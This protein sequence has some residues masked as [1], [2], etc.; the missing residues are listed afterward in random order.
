MQNFRNTTIIFCAL[1]M[2]V[3]SAAEP[4]QARQEK[5]R[6]WVDTDAACV[7]RFATDVDDCWAL[8]LLLNSPNIQIVGIS[9][10]FGN[11]ERA[12]SVGEMRALLSAVSQV[13][14]NGRVFPVVEGAHEPSGDGPRSSNAAVEAL[15]AELEKAP[16]TVLALG[17]LTNIASATKRRPDLWHQIEQIVAVAGQ[18]PGERFYPGTSRLLHVHDMNFQKDVDAFETVL[19]LPTEITLIPYAA[20]SQVMIR[21]SQLSLM[22]RDTGKARWLAEIS[23]E[24]LGFWQDYFGLPGFFPFDLV[25]AGYLVFPDGMKCRQTRAQVV[26]RRGLFT[27]RDTLEVGPELGRAIRY[28]DEVQ[29]QFGERLISGILE[30]PQ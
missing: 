25:A 15:I 5:Q 22:Q 13:D 20:G 7:S 16:L 28:C 30:N 29:G 4:A 8:A 11:R 21:K 2:A 27:V 24:W 19:A 12:P 1:I 9:T 14:F 10:V 17:P 18:L 3:L 26:R 6:L 23:L